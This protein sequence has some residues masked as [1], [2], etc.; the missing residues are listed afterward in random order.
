[1]KKEVLEEAKRLEGGMQAILNSLD[2]LYDIERHIN[3]HPGS[4][5]SISC[6]GTWCELNHFYDA[7]QI[8]RDIETVLRTRL[9]ILKKKLE[10]L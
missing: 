2:K 10:D 9:D 1:M 8:L 4:K 7:K 5:T 6:G 3:L